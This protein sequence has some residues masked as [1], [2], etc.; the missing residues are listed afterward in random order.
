MWT[1]DRV[2]KLGS[3]L[4]LSAG[5]I[6]PSPCSVNV[7]CITDFTV[8]RRKN[9][10]FFEIQYHHL[11]SPPKYDRLFLVR[12]FHEIRARFWESCFIS[13]RVVCATYIAIIKPGD[14]H[15]CRIQR[16]ILEGVAKFTS[17]TDLWLN[18]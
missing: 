8:T 18:C 15:Q 9:S 6:M 2:L 4:K 13:R 17:E 7:R 14:L 1:G 11:I 3:S 12:G 16:W 5:I 10:A